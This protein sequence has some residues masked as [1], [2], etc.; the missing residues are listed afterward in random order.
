MITGNNCGDYYDDLP[1]LQVKQV[2]M[3]C[4]EAIYEDNV[5]KLKRYSNDQNWKSCRRII[6][7]KQSK[8]TVCKRECITG[9]VGI[10]NILFC[11][12]EG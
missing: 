10:K 1:A 5:W 12:A 11:L 4:F 3:G 2:K 8:N 6:V 9:L 7:L